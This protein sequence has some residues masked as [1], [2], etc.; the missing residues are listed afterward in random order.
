MSIEVATFG[1]C[2]FTYLTLKWLL[3]SVSPNMDLQHV[4]ACESCVA[5]IALERPNVGMF[6]LVMVFIMTL[7]SKGGRALC[8][9]MWLVPFMMV[10]VILETCSLIVKFVTTFFRAVQLHCCFFLPNKYIRL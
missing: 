8:A 2:F 10:N 1:E 7:S 9:L 6:A 5:Y 4:F 3:S